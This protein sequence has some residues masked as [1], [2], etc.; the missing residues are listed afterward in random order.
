MARWRRRY[1]W[2][3][4][5]EGIDSQTPTSRLGLSEDTP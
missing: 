5:H 2:H 1:N 3:R 4:P